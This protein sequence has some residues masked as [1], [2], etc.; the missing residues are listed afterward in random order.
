MSCDAEPPQA[1]ILQLHEIP[2]LGGDTLFA[3]LYA[4]YDALSERMQTMVDGLTALHSGEE[5]FRHVFQFAHQ[6]GNERWPEHSHPIVRK[7][8][9]SGRPALFVDREFTKSIDDLP[10]E[11]V[12]R[13]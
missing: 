11:E 8:A 2:K 5:A 13:R 6:D 1:S 4:A 3:S 10:K 9:D 12:S 7:H